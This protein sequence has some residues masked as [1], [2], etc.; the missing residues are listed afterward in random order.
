MRS[1]RVKR[2]AGE[3]K[4]EREK[5]ESAIRFVSPNKDNAFDDGEQS[6]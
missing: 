2:T 3:A 1:E 6:I 5:M 4:R